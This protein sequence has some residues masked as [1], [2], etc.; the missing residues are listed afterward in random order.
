MASEHTW[1]M[2]H[3]A[4]SRYTYSEKVIEQGIVDGNRGWALLEETNM[5]RDIA[6]FDYKK[7]FR[8]LMDFSE[9]RLGYRKAVTSENSNNIP[10]ISVEYGNEKRTLGVYLRN[11]SPSYWDNG[12]GACEYLDIELFRFKDSKWRLLDVIAGKEAIAPDEVPSLVKWSDFAE[13][14]AKKMKPAVDF[15]QTFR[16]LIPRGEDDF[17]YV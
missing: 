16:P 4:S 9:C 11:C 17:M 10:K 5:R 15:F 2:T 3:S 13:D 8:F 1:L 12:F 6:S 7:K 14:I